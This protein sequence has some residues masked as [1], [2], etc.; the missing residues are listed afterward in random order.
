MCH[1]NWDEKVNIFDCSN[2][3]ITSLALQFPNGTTWFIAKSNHIPRLDWSQNLSHIQ[4]LDLQNSSIQH[5][6]D[7]F[8]SK[9]QTMKKAKFLNLENNN[10]RSFPKSLNGTNFSQV[11]LAGNP[12]DCNCDMLWFAHWLNTT[13]PQSQNRIVKDYKR[14]LCAGGKWNGTQVYTLNAEQM[15]CFPVIISK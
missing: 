10:L 2:T 13:E 1:Y 11:Y 15:G 12:I 7:D 8:F 9:I 4:H 5:I 6:A 3:N 14:V